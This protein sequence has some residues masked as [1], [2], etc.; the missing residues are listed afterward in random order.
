MNSPYLDKPLRSLARAQ[1]ET[2]MRQ[3]HSLY[4][5]QSQNKS[6]EAFCHETGYTRSSVFRWALEGTPTIV[7]AFLALKTL[8]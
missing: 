8:L 6:I 3:I 2:I 5:C 1:Q 4:G 7:T